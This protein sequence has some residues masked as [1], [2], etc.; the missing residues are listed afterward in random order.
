[1]PRSMSLSE[2]P[3]S[4]SRRKLDENEIRLDPSPVI[5]KAFKLKY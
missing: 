4:E 3:K 2:M 5:S 1:M